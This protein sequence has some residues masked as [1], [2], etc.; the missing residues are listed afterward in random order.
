MKNNSLVLVVA[1][2]LIVFGL[3]SFDLSQVLPNIS[4]PVNNHMKMSAPKDPEILKEAQDVAAIAK[5]MT[6]AEAGTLRD[7]YLDIREL[8]RLDGE[9]EVIKNTEAIREA[10]S[11][12]GHMLNINIKGKYP[13]L[14]KEC[15]EV[16]VAAI[17][18]DV[19]VLSPELR[20]KAM[21]GFYA[22]A[23]ALNERLN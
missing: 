13:N 15:K 2:L 16:I 17:G 12:A 11:I 20:T 9:N 7:L 8:I 3:S 21:D 4:K 14:P 5:T 19:L 22:L 1:G 18:D 6:E 10:N 23:W